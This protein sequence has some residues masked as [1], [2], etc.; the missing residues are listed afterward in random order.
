VTISS[1][2]PRDAGRPVRWSALGTT[3]VLVCTGDVSGAREAAEHEI[4]AMDGAASRFGPTSELSRLN[5]RAGRLVGISPLLLEALQLAIRAAA[6]T[7]GAVDPTLGDRMVAL[8]YDRDFDDLERVAIDTPLTTSGDDAHT[9]MPAWEAVELRT[10]PP[11]ARLPVGVELDLGATAKALAADR[12]ARAAEQAAGGGVLL[13][14]GG[15]I[16]TAG[17][18]PETGWAVR[19]T[20]DHRD[21]TGAGQHVTLQGGGLATSSLV[22]RRWRHAGRSYHHVLDPRAGSPVRPVWRTASVAAA[23]CA[24]ANIA[25]T[26]AL[27]LGSQARGWLEARGLPARL[28]AVDGS[29][30]VLGGWPE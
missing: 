8:G 29:V 20:D 2:Q 6:L 22:A 30:E 11:A 18:P 23:T 3:A 15:D 10:H 17:H 13:A 1:R 21:T 4:R 7:D 5:H 28:V 16:A 27:V 25:S 14:L 24:E 12:G 9:R 19:V 26:A